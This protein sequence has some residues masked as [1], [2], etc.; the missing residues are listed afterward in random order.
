M[1]RKR[2]SGFLLV[3]LLAVVGANLVPSASATLID[4]GNGTV[5]DTST[6]L[7]WLKDANYAAGLSAGQINTIISD[8]GAVAGHTLTTADFAGSGLMTWWGAMAWAQDLTFAGSDDWRL[9]TMTDTGAPGCAAIAFMGTDCGY[10]VDLATGE[11]ARLWYASLGNTAFYDTSGNQTGCSLSVPYCFTNQS[12]FINALPSDIYLDWSPTEYA[13]LNISAWYFN[14]YGGYQYAVVK[15]QTAHG[16]AV[17]S[18]TVPEP[19]TLALLFIGLTGYGF[20]R[21][22]R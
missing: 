12:P 11:L 2:A 19:G 10:N 4:E 5:L 6:N 13:P 16:W 9:P 15:E 20:A 14:V 17:R 3:A 7:L 18:A 21:R 8:V 22:E 1:A